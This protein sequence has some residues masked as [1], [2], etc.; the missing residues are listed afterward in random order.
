MFLVDRF[1]TKHRQSDTQIRNQGRRPLFMGK[2][3]RTIEK[4]TGCNNR[5]IQVESGD[6]QKNDRDTLQSRKR[7]AGEAMVIDQ[8]RN[9]KST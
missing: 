2:N 7:V 8:S 4:T 9:N 6:N 1:Y 3:N 5:T